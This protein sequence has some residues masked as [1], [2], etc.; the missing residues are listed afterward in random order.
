LLPFRRL[1]VRLPKPPE[2]FPLVFDILLPFRRID[3]MLGKPNSSSSSSKPISPSSRS[4][5]DERT[6]SELERKLVYMR[7]CG[8]GDA[9]VLGGGVLLFLE[10]VGGVR[11]RELLD[12]LLCSVLAGSDC[13]CTCIHTDCL[14]SR[15]RH[16]NSLRQ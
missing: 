15:C 3:A 4:C 9:V 7:L 8:G 10:S 12:R 14:S 6:S 5:S 1:L 11:G 16:G 13:Q 2:L